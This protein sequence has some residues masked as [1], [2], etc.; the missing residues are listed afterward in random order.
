MEDTIARRL[1]SYIIP[2]PT[3]SLT[4]NVI[5]APVG[6]IEVTRVVVEAIVVGV[7]GEEVV[8]EGMRV[9]ENPLTLAGREDDLRMTAERD[10]PRLR[11]LVDGN[12]GLNSGK[13]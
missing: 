12:S 2:H 10:R 3:H 8:E 7:V 9:L 11:V 6:M 13:P 1:P 4:M 5:S